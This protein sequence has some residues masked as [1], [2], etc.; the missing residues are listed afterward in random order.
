MTERWSIECGRGLLLRYF[1]PLPYL[2]TDRDSWAI[3][4]WAIQSGNTFL[5]DIVKQCV[6]QIQVAQLVCRPDVRTPRR[7]TSSLDG[8]RWRFRER[9]IVFSSRRQIVSRASDRQGTARGFFTRDRSPSRGVVRKFY[10]RGQHSMRHSVIKRSSVRPSVC[11]SSQSTAVAAAGGFAAVVGRL[12]RISVDSCCYRAT[13]GPRK[14]WS[15]CKEVQHTCFLRRPKISRICRHNVNTKR[16]HSQNCFR[17][18]S[19]NFLIKR[20]VTL[21]NL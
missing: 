1:I 7:Q 20:L 9:L 13:C 3:D 5:Y 14:F 18:S 6:T 12:Q 17:T 19:S 11:L 15:D 8:C 21:L 4:V 16:Q 2:S 10:V